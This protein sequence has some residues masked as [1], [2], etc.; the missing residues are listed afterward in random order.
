MLKNLKHLIAI[1]FFVL[2]SACQAAD[3]SGIVRIYNDTG[4]QCTGVVIENEGGPLVLT[5]AHMFWTQKNEKPATKYNVAFYNDS[6]E[7]YSFP[8]TLLKKND[9]WDLALMRVKAEV[10][11]SIFSFTKDYPANAK[12]VV[13]GYT[14]QGYK[15][16]NL[17]L[18]NIKGFS[19]GREPTLFFDGFVIPGQSGAPFLYNDSIIGITS[20]RTDKMFPGRKIS[21]GSGYTTLE[22]FLNDNIE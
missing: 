12:I 7:E 14:R 8:A 20:G 10:D 13:Y 2:I 16:T 4:H 15:T 17:T 3:F 22:K 19:K 18:N 6:K 11:T 21:I 5:C 9:D 1:S